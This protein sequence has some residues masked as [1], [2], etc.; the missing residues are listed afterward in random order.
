M[1]FRA[2]YYMHLSLSKHMICHEHGEINYREDHSTAFTNIVNAINNITKKNT[3][4]KIKNLCVFQVAARIEFRADLIRKLHTHKKEE[5]TN[6]MCDKWQKK[7]SF[8]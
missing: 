4:Q 3:E 6:S 2:Q 5:E 8:S 7:K 1:D